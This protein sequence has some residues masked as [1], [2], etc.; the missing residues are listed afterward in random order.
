MS[1]LSTTTSYKGLGSST[2]NQRK[3]I[4]GSTRSS[5]PGPPILSKQYCIV[6]NPQ[7]QITEPSFQRGSGKKA[8]ALGTHEC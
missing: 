3:T 8:R 6:E 5:P 7:N 1:T 4:W 2:S